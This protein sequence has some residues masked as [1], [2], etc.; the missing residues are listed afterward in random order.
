MVILESIMPVIGCIQL[1]FI[2][3]YFML[4]GKMWIF[5]IFLNIFNAGNLILTDI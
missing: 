3:I 5:L 1:Y 2:Y 4:E